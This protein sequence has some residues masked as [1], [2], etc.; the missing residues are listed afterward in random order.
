MTRYNRPRTKADTVSAVTSEQVPTGRTYEGA[1]GYA[2][3][4]M[5]E[6]FL[7][8]VAYMGDDTFYETEGERHARLTGLVHQIAVDIDGFDWLAG[9]VPWLRTGANMRTASVVVALETVRAR[10]EAGRVP[11]GR[12]LLA[13]ALQRA[14]EPG[15][16]IA[17][18]TAKYGRKGRPALPMPVKRGIGDAALRLYAEYPLM[19]YDTAAHGYRF[20]DVLALVH[21]GDRSGSSQGGRFR[22]PWQHSLFGY[23]ID[24]RYGR[25]EVPEDLRMIVANQRLRELAGEN[26]S[27]LLDAQSLKDAGMTWEDVL[28]LAGSKLDKAALWAAII[29]SMG[30]FALL[31]NLRNM[32]E[33][34][35]RD[36][37]LAPVIAKLTDQATIQRSRLFPFRFL[38]AYNATKQSLRWNYPLETAMQLSLANVPELRGSSLILVDRSGSMAVPVSTH[39]DMSRMDQAAIF[40]VALAQR[41]QEATLVQFGTGSEVV[42]IGKTEALLAAMRKFRDM[43]GTQ[44]A[45]AVRANFR[46]HDRVVIV[47]DEQAWGGYL[48]EE[49]TSAVSARVPVYTWNLA[50]YKHGH[51]SSGTGNRHTFGGMSDAAFQ[52]IQLLEAGRTAT[53][54]WEPV[55]AERVEDVQHARTARRSE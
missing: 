7:L 10:L 19:K 3:E 52:M 36:A 17:Y 29:P 34:R 16:A 28:S 14:D 23:A 47:T 46:D 41:A 30:I 4:P 44:T 43:G 1:P 13:S 18:W 31:R 8:A 25:S 22:G 11:A 49:P 39:S 15:E 53:W 33:A 21:A 26:P 42:R 51:G 50:G 24:R 35:V 27:V 37:D 12:K 32:D 48:G 55:R 5:S 9:F 45:S 20:A 54:P 6:L 2:R 40:G 38:S